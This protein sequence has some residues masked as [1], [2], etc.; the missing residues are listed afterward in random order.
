MTEPDLMQAVNDYL[1]L[2]RA[3][4]YQ[5]LSE[6]SLLRSLARFALIRGHRG[7]LTRALAEDW[8]RASKR[9]DPY[10][11][12]RRLAVVCPFARYLAGNEPDTQIPDGHP[13]GPSH[14]RVPPRV[15]SAKEVHRL[16]SAAAQ[17]P[18]RRGLAPRTYATLFG[19]LACTGLRVSEAIHLRIGDVDLRDGVLRIRQTKFGKSRLVPLHPSAI[20]ALE[21]Y[22]RQR[23]ARTPVYTDQA[24]F[25]LDGGIPLT[26]SRTRNAFR[27]VRR[28]LGW[29]PLSIGIRPTLRALRHTFA[30]RR[31]AAWYADSSDVHPRVHALSTYL[32]H[33]KISDT[34]WYLSGIPELMAIAA[35][36]FV[37]PGE[38]AGAL[39]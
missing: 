4:G 33:G 9:T 2:R 23:D 27:R 32:G 21:Q 38:N 18:P 17:L 15:L 14:R 22:A 19:L 20:E 6:E 3:L 24:F 29:E 30:C 31:L 11:W 28:Q 13:F 5:L 35:R 1:R 8:A 10:T 16:I 25:K 12:S 34:Y 37:I 36:R 7:P 39:S 26:Y